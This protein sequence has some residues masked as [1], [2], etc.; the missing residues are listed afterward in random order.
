M[1]PFIIHNLEKGWY[2][3]STGIW[4]LDLKNDNHYIPLGWG[5]GKVWKDGSNILNAFIEPQWT[6][7]KKGDGMP[8]F[9]LF[10]GLNATFG[11]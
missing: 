5:G 11:K 1:Q 3:R 6:V 10:V 2:L 7:E 8:Q 9:T 4:T